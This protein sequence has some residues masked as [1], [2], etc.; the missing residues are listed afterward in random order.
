[1]GKEVVRILKDR[2]WEVRDPKALQHHKVYYAPGG[3]A[4]GELAVQG[5][6]FFEGEGELYAFILEK[7]MV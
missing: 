5:E 2:G 6:D 1:M 4:K 7:G 3:R